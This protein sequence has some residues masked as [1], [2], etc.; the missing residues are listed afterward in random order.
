M[1]FHFH[2]TPTSV[3]IWYTKLGAENPVV[4][5]RCSV[6]YALS[7]SE[8]LLLERVERWVAMLHVRVSISA[9]ETALQSPIEPPIVGS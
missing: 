3:E 6:V 7:D 5:G 2:I 1:Q 8:L 9:D 4:T